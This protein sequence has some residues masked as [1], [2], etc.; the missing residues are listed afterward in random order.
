MNLKENILN[1]AFS[2]IYVEKDAF[3][4]KYTDEILEKFKNSI[5]VEI[6][7][8][9]DVFSRENQEFSLQKARPKLILAVKKDEYLY[10]GADVCED[11]GNKNFY[12]VSSVMNCIYDCEYCYLQGVY[13]SGNI[14]IFV[15]IEDMFNEISKESEDGKEL[16]ICISYDT[17][18]LGLD[19]IT[20][21]VKRWYSF[22]SERDNIKIEL[23]SKSG[24][25]G[26]LKE[27]KP[28][29]NFIIAWT[30]SPENVVAKYERGSGSYSARI[31]AIK[32]LQELGWS[33]RLCFDPLIDIDNFEKEYI[34]MVDRSFS[35]IQID[36]ILDVSIGTFR[37]SKEYMKR[38][39][40]NRINSEILNYPF[41][42]KNGVYSYR[43][44][45]NDKMIEIVKERVLKYI[46]REKIYI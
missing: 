44:S 30:L 15:N 24:N 31:E 22:V 37:I 13:S 8:Y 6:E 36:K 2:H 11:F 1:K 35:S 29:D 43:D 19:S 4:Y 28:I 20:G 23:R 16:Y 41:V 42:S 14:V 38:M 5:I 40:K 3:N 45:K 10:K 12:Y 34:E 33:I 25:I 27:L 26:I 21:M 17:D 39:R 18:L 9:K 32:K 7:N 46:E